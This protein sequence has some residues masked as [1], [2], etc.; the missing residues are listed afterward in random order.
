MLSPKGIRCLGHF[1][2]L[3]SILIILLASLVQ[4]TYRFGSIETSL[5][6]RHSHINLVSCIDNDQ[7]DLC[8]Q[9]IAQY[10]YHWFG[11]EKT[12]ERNEGELQSRKSAQLFE[13]QLDQNNHVQTAMI[14]FWSPDDCPQYSTINIYEMEWCI[15]LGC[16]IMPIC[17]LITLNAIDNKVKL[18]LQRYYGEE[19]I[20]DQSDQEFALLKMESDSETEVDI[21][22]IN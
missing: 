8:A 19:L 1:A 16:F 4:L 10:S 20:P 13:T 11:N 5:T 6:L 3:L 7:I 22:V 2:S 18:T 21:V 9:V 15:F 12:C 17:M 14:S